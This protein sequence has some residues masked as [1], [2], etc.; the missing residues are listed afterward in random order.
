MRKA[1]L[2]ERI[3]K[4]TGITRVEIATVV[5]SFIAEVREAVADGHTIELR[6]LGTFSSRSRSARQG[7][8]PR[9]G[10]NVQVPAKRV[11]TF[12]VSLDWK[13]SL[14]HRVAEVE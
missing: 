12:R 2:V 5:D 10:D 7:K 8:N 11:P 6:G 14:Q 3:A 13:K 4:Q 9:T 1:E